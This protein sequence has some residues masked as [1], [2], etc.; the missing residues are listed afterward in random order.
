MYTS[1]SAAKYDL[2]RQ[3][4]KHVSVWT[5]RL[6]TIQLDRVSF[7]RKSFGRQCMMVHRF[8]CR[9]GDHTELEKFQSTQLL[10]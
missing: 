4:P 7:A 5:V 8:D 9:M 6:L 2:T 1:T 3:A 10:L